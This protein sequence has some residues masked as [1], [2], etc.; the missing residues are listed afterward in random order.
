MKVSIVIPVY[1]MD[2]AVQF[3]TR[4]IESILSQTFKDYEI[5]ISDDSENSRLEDWVKQYPVKYF[6]NL[7][8]KGMANN[9]N[10]AMDKATGDLI[11]ILFQDDYFYD[12]S[13]L[14]D[15]V[16]HFTHWTQWLVTPCIHSIREGEIFNEH[17]P[18]YSETENTIGSP[19]VLTIRREIKERFDPQFN[20]VLD[21]DFYKRLFKKYGLPKITNKINVIIGIGEHQE[22]NKLSEERKLLEYK[23]LREKYE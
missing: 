12:E 16:K 21:L 4:N 2:N 23:L 19:S 1:D 18:Y 7:G 8:P 22:T 6:R 3:T 14:W 11:K 15:I 20:W 17:K 9:T 13:S 5:I 10:Y